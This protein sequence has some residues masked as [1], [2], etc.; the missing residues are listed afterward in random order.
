MRT[1]VETRGE[2]R[3]RKARESQRAR[4][5]NQD[6]REA[7][8]ESNRARIAALRKV[9]KRAKVEARI[10]RD[11]QANEAG[12][13]LRVME[14]NEEFDKAYVKHADWP[15]PI[16]EEK[17]R[18][19]LSE[20]RR[21]TDFDE[22]RELVCAIC[23]GLYTRKDWMKVS[24]RDVELT[25][26]QAPLE[27]TDPSNGIDYR[28]G[29]PY[30]DDSG[31]KVLLDRKGFIYDQEADG[32]PFDLR[33]C[34]ACHRSLRESK[35][36]PLSLA[37]MW[38]GP[39][40]AC[41]QG[42]TIPE[43]LMM[44]PSYLCVHIVQLSNKRHRH[45]KL[46]GHIITFP[47]NPGSLTKILPHPMYQ[48]CE[49]L[50]VVF[51]GQGNPTEK[52]LKN[53]LEVRKS[54]V[55]AALRWLL[56]H[57]T[58]FKDVQID[59]DALNALPEGEVPDALRVT[60]T[61]VDVDSREVEHYTGYIR[62]P[63]DA[64]NDEDMEENDEMAGSSLNT[65]GEAYELRTSGILHVDSVPILEQN[66][67]LVSLQN[68]IDGPKDQLEGT[69]DDVEADAE[70][71][72]RAQIIRMP[73]TNKPLSEF[74]NPSFFPSA[75]PVL[76]CYGH[77]GWNSS[78]VSLAVYANHLM[79]HSDTKF[80]QHRSFPFVIFDVLQRQEV[81]F[82]TRI[83]AKGK[84]FA[85]S[86]ELIASLT[87]E[88]MKIAIEQEENNR[89]LT[90]PAVVELLRNINAVGSRLMASD[91]SRRRM[92]NEIRAITIRDGASSLF[93]T[94]NPADL[95]SPIVMMYAG[96]EI[97]IEEILAD[98]PEKFPTAD[99]R[100][101]L[102]HLDPCAVA[103]YFDVVVKGIL[104]TIV[105]YGK[106]NGGVFGSVKNYYGVVE[107]Q[108]RGTPHCHMLVWLHGVPDPITM[109]R[110]LMDDVEFCQRVLSYVSDIVKED[111]SYLLAEG[112]ALT[113]AMLK[114][115]F[116]RK[117]TVLE[118]RMHPSFFPIPDPHAPDFEEK[119]RLDLLAIVRR[120]L[121]H[122]CSPTC[123]K[124]A[125][126]VE[127][128]CRFD[129]PREFV[130]RPGMVV[131]EHGII[132]VPRANAYI[133]NHNPYV[134]AACRG[135]NDI[136]F[137]SSRK[138]ALTYIQY[139]TDYI[140]KSDASTHS[141]FLMCAATLETFM[142]NAVDHPSLDLVDKSRKFVTKCLNKIAGQK[143]LT[144]PQVSAYLLGIPDH[145]TPCRFVTLHL[146]TFEFFLRMEW[147]KH[148][149]E[150]NDTEEDES[151]DD[152]ECDLTNTKESE[153]FPIPQSGDKFLAVNL[154]VDYKFRGPAL[155][156]MCLYD[157]TAAVY[158]VEIKNRDSSFLAEQST[159]EGAAR[160]DRFLFRGGETECDETCNHEGF[161]PQHRTHIQ[162]QCKHGK[163]KLVV[164]AGRGI[165]K[166]G[167]RDNAERYGL[168][169]LALFKPWENVEDLHGGYN[170]WAEA[171]QAFLDNPSLSPRL[172]S[173]ISNIELLHRCSEEAA[174]DRQL[175]E[176]SRHD[177]TLLKA[178]RVERSVPGY[179][180]IEEEFLMSDD[181]EDVFP[182]AAPNAIEHVIDP[183]QIVK[184]GL[185]NTRM[186]D[187]AMKHLRIR[188]RLTAKT[189]AISTKMTEDDETDSEYGEDV[190]LVSNDSI[191]PSNSEDEENVRIW[192]SIISTRKVAGDD[193][194]EAR[195][196]SSTIPCAYIGVDDNGVTSMNLDAGL[197]E[198]P[199]EKISANLNE[200]Q[201]KAFLLV[202]DHRRR[203]QVDSASKLSQL[204]LY[205]AGAGGTGKT[206]V[207]KAI[208]DYFD[209]IGKR[210]T[211]LV[212]AYTGIAASNISGSTIHSM[213]GFGFG[214][215]GQK[216]EHLSGTTLAQLQER[217][218]KIEYVIIDEISTIGQK[219]LA[220]LHACIKIAK[221]V[222]NDEP[223]AGM[224][225]LFAGDFMQLPPVRDPALYMPN[226]VVRVTS[227]SDSS[228]SS[229]LY[230]SNGR[231]RKRQNKPSPIGPSSVT[232][233][234][235]R[236]LWLSVKHVVQ[237]KQ[238]MRQ[239]DDPFYAEVLDSMRKGQ[240]SEMQRQALR[241][242]ILG[243]D[244][245]AT[246][247]WKDAV[248]LVSRNQIRVQI[249]FDA[250]LE[251]ANEVDQHVIYSCAEDTY[252]KIP[253][254]GRLRKS[255][256]SAPDTKENSLCGIL[257][258]S[259]GMKIVF[260]VNVCT[261]DGLANGAQG[262]LRQI[263]YDQDSIDRPSSRGK[264]VVLKRPPKYVI[265]EL[266]SRRPGAYDNLPTN[267]VPVYPVK[268]ACVHSI[269]RRDGSK[270]ERTFQ[271]FQLPLTP[272][273]AFTDY[274]CQGQTL[275]KA[276]V[277]LAEGVSSTGMYVMLSRVR[278][279][280]DLLILRPFKESLLDIRVPRALCEEI[281]RLED[282]AR[283]TERLKR[284]PDKNN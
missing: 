249:N 235:G 7:E 171:C 141:S 9:K 24:P 47:Q 165:P 30:V 261:Q 268:L 269:W 196:A 89:P 65:I 64:E 113:D 114:E 233:A 146:D 239:L 217:W 86:A 163:E 169:I 174:L 178:R 241:S 108:D 76:F 56:K 257:P 276:I 53:V 88:D 252:K 120:T 205:L 101:R 222:E 259:I 240:L 193:A 90:N 168:C 126:G 46:K 61:L 26:L 200:E 274:K 83:M 191:R 247:E 218:S 31:L 75:F 132:A 22:L 181:G 41:L 226:K 245:I 173:I 67:T 62:D 82:Q 243:D 229:A 13:Q 50:K 34:T 95:Q 253:L 118:K 164:L 40:P 4:R 12:I 37:S 106:D 281:K 224:N 207:I 220:R 49:R 23:S 179:D 187:E 115:D 263:V 63:L 194:D 195:T 54:R 48:L 270:I 177:A 17:A 138:H 211:I 66:R 246:Q 74:R 107:Y 93:I 228:L 280:D 254:Q 44:S 105:G 5:A 80:R 127:R 140:T 10:A 264:E 158:K 190:K 212:L 160:V 279:L 92:R 97:D 57:N 147:A 139:I 150:T 58:L 119:F 199:I 152:D 143:E 133:N 39:T 225:I 277:D 121:Y 109:R 167:D 68:I 186:I 6:Y 231:K 204:L 18:D 209:A 69:T 157:Y 98:D 33:I 38:I 73:H 271:R 79:R 242:R 227:N 100:A 206:T 208:C 43:Q 45:H 8:K 60:T 29:H 201:R 283:E 131:P 116:L 19:S 148:Q 192:R 136:K 250:T 111:V 96:K 142:T 282:C 55:A 221:A 278:K 166:K 213:C 151:N 215:E 153:S 267:H 219:L 2:A 202:C 262:I 125:R 236:D 77:G 11:Q 175:R 84:S 161:H 16:A 14:L 237:L 130:E 266:I 188:G 71:S 273:F 28:Y 70:S 129:F 137:I 78:N 210:D 20:Y 149:G 117:K 87:S 214:K 256:L 244:R 124:Y 35:T 110:R 162:I 260:T 51:V 180:A 232:S 27:L 32:D 72:E 258:L 25:L 122:T 102:A 156:N 234:I 3:K 189:H 85:R 42:L 15:K 238:P 94:I 91:Q 223:F 145:Y 159:R 52:Q 265:V 104:D 203:N 251:H 99:E 155:R 230:R 170:S 172:R 59:E 185:P 275:Q 182:S 123:K 144:G 284:W 248:F 103:K 128:N 216:R 134:T 1:T 183:A 184:A 21:K 198:D 255:F 112:E 154:R 176:S 135:N 272:A 81:L 197:V 36:P